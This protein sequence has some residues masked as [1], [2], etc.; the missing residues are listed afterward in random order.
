MKSLFTNVPLQE[1][2]DVILNILKEDESL[3][4][5]T[6]LTPYRTAELVRLCL[7]ST[8][9]VYQG[10]YYEQKEGAVVDSPVSAVMANLFFKKLALTSSSVKPVLWKRYVDDT[11]CIMKRDK[12]D[13]FLQH[14]NS[15]KLSIKFTVELEDRGTCCSW[16]VN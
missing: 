8:Y 3:Q 16:I 5:R 4:D 6:V 1:A 12:V 14:L 11:F 13:V 7:N 15:I 9:F 2:V 10:E